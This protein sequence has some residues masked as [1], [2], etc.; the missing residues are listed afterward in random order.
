LNPGHP[1]FLG[2]SR[3]DN[4]G[5]IIVLEEELEESALFGELAYRITDEWAVTVGARFFETDSKSGN[6]TD[7]P[8]LNTFLGVYGPDGTNINVQSFRFDDDGVLF[9]LNSSYRFSENAMG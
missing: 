5:I 2:I 7:F 4:L 9:K 8:I 3:P 6:A 1:E